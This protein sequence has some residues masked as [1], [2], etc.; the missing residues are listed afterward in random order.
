MGS[1]TTLERVLKL[2]LEQFD[3][4]D[5]KVTPDATLGDMHIDS[6]ESVELVIAIEQDFKLEIPDEEMAKLDTAAKLAAY[7]DAR[8]A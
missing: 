3:V 2:I 4:E 1:G 8:I 6:L 7:L 5:E